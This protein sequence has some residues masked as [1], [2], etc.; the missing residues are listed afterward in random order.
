MKRA[1]GKVESNRFLSLCWCYTFV[2]LSAELAAMRAQ[3]L[4][5]LNDALCIS[6]IAYNAM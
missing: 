6:T 1:S 4:S 3:M 5:S 2:P